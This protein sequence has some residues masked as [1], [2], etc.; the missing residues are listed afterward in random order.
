MDSLESPNWRF[1][2]ASECRWWGEMA[3]GNG[4]WPETNHLEFELHVDRGCVFLGR[5]IR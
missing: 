1:S 2:I 5:A 4:G 3:C